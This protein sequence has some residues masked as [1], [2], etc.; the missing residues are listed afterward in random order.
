MHDFYTV[1][2]LGQFRDGLQLD[3]ERFEDLSP[4]E[5]QQHVDHIFSE[6]VSRH[7]DEHFLKNTSRASV[8]SPAI[9]LLFEYVR[10]AHFPDRPSR[11][12][13]W[14]GTSDIQSALEFRTQY[15]GASD[16]LWVISAEHSFR[17]N[18]R[19]L[20]SDRSTLMYSHFAHL[21]WSGEQ[22]PISALWENLLVPPVHVVRRV[23]QEEIHAAQQIQP[24][25]GL[26]AWLD[27]FT[28]IP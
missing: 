23:S 10:R 9:E 19:L 24:P 3:L 18:M 16:A 4:P 1:D 27:E 17:A 15:R 12:Q 8:A 21:Y 20:T 5:L 13:S 7:G 2:G 28:S 6:G 26:S 14:F 22:G 11:F 25:Q